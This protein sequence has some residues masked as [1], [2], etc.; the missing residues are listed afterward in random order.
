MSSKFF[1]IFVLI[2]LI[3][4]NAVAIAQKSEA[5][6]EATDSIAW[7]RNDTSSLKKKKHSPNKATILSAIL[8]GLGQTYNR[9]YWKVPIIVGAGTIFTILIH[10]NNHDWQQ[11]RKD[12]NIRLQ[13]EQDGYLKANADPSLYDAYDPKSPYNFMGSG[14][15]TYST[16][17][18]RLIRDSYRRDRDFFI[19]ISALVY[20]L[21]IV[22]AAVFAHLREFEV[23]EKLSMKINPE[24]HFDFPQ[25]TAGLSC[26]FYFKK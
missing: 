19:I 1:Q 12:Y 15:R 26:R 16:Q 20:T 7:L 3:F 11:A 23:S 9:Q 24:I 17:Q 13:N 10:S 25:P 14:V 6:K 4:S 5:Q 18:L 22:D 21:N 2:G 8:P